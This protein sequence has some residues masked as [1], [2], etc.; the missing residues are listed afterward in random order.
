MSGLCTIFFGKKG[1]TAT[2]A[3]YFCSLAREAYREDEMLLSRMS[4]V[5][6]SAY[7]REYKVDTLVSV[8]MSKDK[9]RQTEARLERTVRYKSLIAWLREALKERDRYYHFVKDTMTDEEVGQKCGIE[10][11]KEPEKPEMISEDEWI[12]SLSFERRAKIYDLQT[13]AA[14]FGRAVGENGYLTNART[15]LFD[16]IEHPAKHMEGVKYDQNRIETRTPSVST[17]DID[18]VYFRIL[19]LKRE[20]QTEYNSYI[21]PIL[22][23]MEMENL[24]R[25]SDYE[26][27]LSDYRLAK[28]VN[29]TRIA[30]WRKSEVRRTLDLKIVIPDKL[31]PIYLEL[32][33]LLKVEPLV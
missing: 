27:A 9:L 29:K 10:K 2:S 20:A 31:R 8:G 17:E 22:K 26:K 30:A 21:G 25:M 12:R 28:K 5:N 33:D 7:Y 4:L 13:R 15:Q 3:E 6:V 16:S 23:E 32:C 14:V 19:Q 11:I 18:E 1:L 24:R